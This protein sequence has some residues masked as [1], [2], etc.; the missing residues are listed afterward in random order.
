MDHSSGADLSVVPLEHR[1]LVAC[2]LLQRAHAFQPSW[3]LPTDVAASIRDALTGA[4][5]DIVAPNS[6]DTTTDHAGAVLD[7]LA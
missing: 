2:W 1:R 7:T 6:E 5:V 3:M 4:A